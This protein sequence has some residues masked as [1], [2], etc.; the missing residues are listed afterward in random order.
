MTTSSKLEVNPCSQREARENAGVPLSQ[1]YF[2]F[3]FRLAEK[4]APV[5]SLRVAM[6]NQS[7]PGLLSTLTRR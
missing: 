6:R 5:I 2:K 7:K 4:E 3:Y 1:D